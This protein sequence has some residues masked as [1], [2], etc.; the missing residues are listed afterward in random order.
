[1]DDFE[2][3]DCPRVIDHVRVRGR[4][5]LAGS[6]SRYFP[7]W[8]P[9]MD[10]ARLTIRAHGSRGTANDAAQRC[11]FLVD[12]HLMSYGSLLFTGLPLRSPDDFEAF[13][14]ALD[15]PKVSYS[16]GIAVRPRGA[17]RTMPASLEDQRVTLSPHNEMAY[18]RRFPAKIFFFCAREAPE[19]GE[20]ALKDAGDALSQIPEAIATPFLQAGI[21]Y[22]RNLPL[23]SDAIRIGWPEVFET[24]ERREVEAQ[25]QADGCDYTWNA[26]GA[27]TYSYRRPACIPHPFRSENLWFNQVTEL[28]ASYWRHHPLCAA[29]EATDSAFPATTTYGDGRPI[30][31][32]VITYLRAMLWQ[33]SSA[34]KLH[35]GDVLVL[36]NLTV[37][38]GRFPFW[39]PRQHLVSIAS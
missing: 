8:I 14:R 3:H 29:R 36:D 38:H 11:R 22:V 2:L 21:R 19:G 15:Y 16:G 20:V 7:M 28:H 9:V 33:N 18:L 13:M 4:P 26:D 34:M 5:F 35:A 1:M 12:A 31:A 24:R 6:E 37:Q 39:G 25:L 27:L 32:D 23:E 10:G 30:D 17:G